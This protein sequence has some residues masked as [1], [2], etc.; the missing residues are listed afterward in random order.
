MNPVLILV[1]RELGRPC[2]PLTLAWLKQ[3]GDV[4][5]EGDAV[6]RLSCRSAW[7]AVYAPAAGR[8]SQFFRPGETCA[9]DDILGTITPA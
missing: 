6:A 4:V 8:L 7:Q 1:P 9:R 5:A 3:R 2:E